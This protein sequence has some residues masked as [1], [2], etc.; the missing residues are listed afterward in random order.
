[1]TNKP[2]NLKTAIL[3]TR[4]GMGTGPADMQQKILRSYLYQINELNYLPTAICFYGE[5]VKLTAPGSSVI[6]HLKALE[7]KGVKLFICMTCLKEFDLHKK[8]TVGTIGGMADIIE[9][10]WKADKVITL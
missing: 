8:V 2:E 4:N 6:R 5:G 9:A 7:A 3:I 1:M 10:Q